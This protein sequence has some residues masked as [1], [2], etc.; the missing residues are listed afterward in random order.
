MAAS[1]VVAV[2]L[3]TTLSAT[4]MPAGPA[5]SGASG[6]GGGSRRS[7]DGGSSGSR[8]GSGDVGSP[9]RVA[10]LDE[11]HDLVVA[12]AVHEVVHRDVDGAGGDGL[13]PLRQVLVRDDDVVSVREVG[14]RGIGDLDVREAGG[15]DLVPQH[16]GAHRAGAHS[17]VARKDDVLDRSGEDGD[18]AGIHARTGQGGGNRAL[19]ALQGF[20]PVGGFVQVVFRGRLAGLQDHRGDQEGHVVANSTAS[21]TPT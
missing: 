2:P 16:R 19:L 7:A 4:R 17:G 1:R 6:V 14:D 13:G 10:G 18:A 5:S 11:L 8:R 9:V 21:V 15:L 3:R 20:H 12:R